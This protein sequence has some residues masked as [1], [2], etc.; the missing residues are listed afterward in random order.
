MSFINKATRIPPLNPVR[1]TPANDILPAEYNTNPF[2]RGFFYQSIR[3]YQNDLNMDYQQKFTNTDRIVV[4][5]D[6]LAPAALIT[7]LDSN[8]N[9]VPGAVLNLPTPS[10]VLPGNTYTLPGTTDELQY[11]TFMTSTRATDIGIDDGI[12]YLLMEMIYVTE[13]D[14]DSVYYISESIFI[15]STGWPGTMLVEA[16]NTTNDYDVLFEQLFPVFKSRVECDITN[17]APFFHDTVFEDMSYELRKL[18][19]VPYRN[20]TWI[21]GGAAGV[22]DYMIDKM[23]RYASCDTLRIDGT[24]YVKEIS[25]TYSMNT[26][27]NYPF[28]ASSILLREFDH[29][30]GWIYGG[31]GFTLLVE[32]EL[33]GGSIIFPLAINRIGMHDGVATPTYNVPTVI[34]DSA[35]LTAYLATLN[36]TFSDDND[37]GG[38]FTLT[39]D[40]F[41]IGYQNGVN[42]NYNGI[43]GMYSWS[44]F[45]DLTLSTTGA[46]PHQ[47]YEFYFAGGPS[48]RQGACIVDWGQGTVTNYTSNY[49][50]ALYTAGINYPGSVAANY[51]LRIFHAGVAPGPHTGIQQLKFSFVSPLATITAIGASKAPTGLIRWEMDGQNLSGGNVDASFLKY[52]STTLQFLI[53]ASCQITAFYPLLFNY[54]GVHFT[55]LYL[56]GISV[57]NNALNVTQINSIVSFFELN[58]TYGAGGLFW[59]NETPAAAPTGSDLAFLNTL[60]SAYAW[61]VLHD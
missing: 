59:L 29:D 61:I 22:A 56:G 54:A 12:Y 5:F 45:I 49:Y 39:A 34:A 24:Q 43:T 13:G 23:N 10:Y 17:Y 16:T 46:S 30:G 57:Y 41:G 51:N 20:F 3:E 27:A 58:C 60:V 4:Y 21:V 53:F 18:Q 31:G 6:T 36:G 11:N 38:T 26:T 15:R 32:F 37:L 48:A 35:A 1:F 2:D 44:S 40:G 14:S 55:S 7:V 33:Q 52:C 28:K 47:Y 19:S 42:E 50:G 25:A 8:G 9:P